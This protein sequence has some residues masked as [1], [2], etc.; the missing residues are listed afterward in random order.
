MLWLHPLGN[1]IDKEIKNVW[2]ALNA[3]EDG[4]NVRH[5]FQFV[6]YHMNFDI[7]MEDFHC[8]ACLVAGKHVINVPAMFTYA[9]A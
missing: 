7:E 4:K 3:L 6:K 9:S 1:A 5:G 8:K 2:V